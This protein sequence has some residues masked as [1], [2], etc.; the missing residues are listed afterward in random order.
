MRH[1]T[2][3]RPKQIGA[4]KYHQH[5]YCDSFSQFPHV[6]RSAVIG[7]IAEQRQQRE[8]RHGSDVL[9]KQNGEGGPA[10]LRGQ[11][12]SLRQQLQDQRRRGQRQRKSHH[13]GGIGFEAEQH[14]HCAQH[15]RCCE[16]LAQA[17]S[18]HGFAHDAQTR[19]LQL[20]PDDEQQHHDPKL[21]QLKGL[22]D[23]G[24]DAE[25]PRSDN[26]PG[27]QVGEDRTEPQ[28]PK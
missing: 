18:E 8:H 16:H 9:K 25:P 27:S 20:Q 21:S 10:V 15:S 19:G 22:I 12:A 26:H 1:R 6:L 24:H 11:F 2:Q 28:L 3:Q 17:Q 13:K 7:A 4:R 23:V 14:R 5:Q